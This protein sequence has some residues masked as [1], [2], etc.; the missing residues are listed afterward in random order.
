MDTQMKT[1]AIDEALYEISRLNAAAGTTVFNPA[2]REALIALRD[3]LAPAKPIPQNDGNP[4]MSPEEHGMWDAGHQIMIGD[5]SIKPKRDFGSVGFWDS[6]SRS[7]IRKGWV[8][9]DSAGC[10][11]IPGAGWYD[12]LAGAHKGI[13]L[14]LASR[15]D[16][17]VFHGLSMAIKFAAEEKEIKQGAV[18]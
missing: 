12:T 10:N 16:A 4:Y 13:A 18:A 2:A 8:V 7:H 17:D 9:C 14:L 1:D 6:P 3:A 15:G 5:Y 11:A